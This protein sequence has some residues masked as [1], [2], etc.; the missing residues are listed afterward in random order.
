MRFI[1]NKDEFIKSILNVIKVIQ[2]K[3]INPILINLKLVLDNSGLTLTGSNGDL[4]IE[5]VIPLFK[6]DREIIRDVRP[7]GCL[8]NAK[9]ISD[10]VR[11]IDGNEISFELIDNSVAKIA[12]DKSVFKLNT[13]QVEE[14]SDIDFSKSGI[15]LRFKKEDFVNSINEVA[16]AVAVKETRPTLT[17]INFFG[18]NNL[19]VM[20]AT[21]GARLAT[22]HLNINIETKFNA[23][24]PAK[25]LIEVIKSISDEE[26]VEVYISD[27]KILVELK[28][29]IIISRL[30]SGDYPNLKNIIPKNF[31]YVLDVNAS[32]FLNAIDRI[33]LISQENESVVKLLMTESKVEISSRSQ[34]LGS[35]N[36]NL[37]VFKY[38]GERL[39]ISF[40]ANYV[41]SA[42]RAL[43]S[44]DV[45]LSFIGEMKPFTVTNKNDPNLIQVITPVRTN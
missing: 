15:L 21:D 14:Y 30:T 17:A 27:K 36:E 11:K 37:N 9:L 16:F 20:T 7:G 29:C 44:E 2:P 24:V 10:I 5:E 43:K 4:S 34:L 12:N 38:Q 6:G 3:N 42:I 35:A 23:N 18:E 13:I 31:F 26:F 19:L 45:T 41:I 32:E 8:I 22:K 25:T 40:K 33:S 39:E 1:I 28:N